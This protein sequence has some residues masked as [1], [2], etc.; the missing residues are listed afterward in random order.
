MIGWVDNYC[1]NFED[2]DFIEIDENLKCSEEEKFGTICFVEDTKQYRIFC[3]F[4][5]TYKAGWAE[6]ISDIQ[7]GF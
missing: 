1:V 7:K 5:K 2:E 6:V 4:H 3:I